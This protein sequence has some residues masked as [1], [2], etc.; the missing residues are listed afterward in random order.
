MHDGKGDE[1]KAVDLRR[2]RKWG[3]ERKRAP[4]Y[5][6]ESRKSFFQN[7]A[8]TVSSERHSDN[9]VV[10]SRRLCI[11]DKVL[12]IRVLMVVYAPEV[13]G[14]SGFGV[15]I[16]NKNCFR[17]ENNM[18]QRHIDYSR[19]CHNTTKVPQLLPL[20]RHMNEKDS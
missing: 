7:S 20:A 15:A 5:D 2:D 11:V 3:R 18:L 16:S 1:R 6:D 19:V 17:T 9:N 8:V 14:A 12:W 10:L 13:G 4:F